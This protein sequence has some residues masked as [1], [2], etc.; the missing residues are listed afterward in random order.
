MKKI[1]LFA[2]LIIPVIKLVAQNKS[3]VKTAP[4][5]PASIL[6][7][8]NDSVSYVVGFSVGNSCKQ[9]GITK[10]NAMLL[11][12]AI[13]DILTGKKSLLND[14]TANACMGRY[15]AGRGN[16]KVNPSTVKNVSILKTLT[17]SASYAI[18]M[19]AGNF[20][21]T[22]GI[23][24][25]N[26]SLVSKSINDILNGKK[27]LCNNETANII[28]NKYMNAEQEEKSKS[29]IDEGNKF[30][31]QNK[32]RAGVNTTASGL[33]YEV[34]TQ[35]TGAKPAATDSVTCHYRGTLLNGTVFDDSYARG[36][37]ITF[38]LNGVIRGWTEGVQLMNVGSK[39][40]F[41]IPYTLGYGPYDYGNIPGG[42]ML[43][44]EVELLDVKKPH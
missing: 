11:S 4:G 16:E 36:Q 31:A 29:T 30:L 6:K 32:L 1:L 15:M 34:I 43:T 22:M 7:T 3:I 8:L 25:L 37:P 40:K 17:D 33:Q 19:N 20:Y 42:S 24:K 14:K 44:F 12:K 18:G 41:Y 35:G 13:N 9:Q 21:K 38:A 26:T 2:V 5:N 27:P 39:Y 10:L 23:T 28:M